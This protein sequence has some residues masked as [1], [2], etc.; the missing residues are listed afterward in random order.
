MSSSLIPRF[1]LPRGLLHHTQK[2]PPAPLFIRH[3]ATRTSPSKPRVLEKPAKFN[4][5]SHPARLN[6]KTPK[7]FPGPPLSFQEMEAQKTK[8]YPHMMPPEGSFMH[9]FLTNKSIHVYITLTF[10][11]SLATFTFLTNFTRTTP[12]SHLLPP[13]S[14]L[15]S[16]PFSFIHQYIE[17]FKLH[18]AHITAETQ[19]RRKRKI[20]DVQ[21]RSEYRKAHGLDKDEG[22][23]GWTAKSE[24]EVMG[25]AL[26]VGEGQGE[27][28]RGGGLDGEGEDKGVYSDWEGKRKPVRKWLG[29][30]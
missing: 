2:S 30:W 28:R 3:A 5:P 24:A 8:Q 17:V 13:T 7:S 14:D 23:G 10:L 21:K 18:T 1:L 12:F 4:P 9:W 15:F 27:G 29:I 19:E 11:F 26:V 20:D 25:P 22:F 16:H 6:K